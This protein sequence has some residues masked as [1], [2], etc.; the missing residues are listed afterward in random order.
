MANK[1]ICAGFCALTIS[2]LTPAVYSDSAASGR[3]DRLEWFLNDKFGMFI[4]W[5]VYSDPAGE[6][7][8]RRGGNYSEWIMNDA[9][10]PAEE[11]AREIAAKFNPVDFEA[12]EW[13]SLAKNAGMKYIVITAK[14]HDGFAMY[15]SR[16]SPYNIVDF[17]PFKRDPMKELAAAC[18]KHGIRLCF[19]YSQT[20]DW[21]HP[22][23]EGN[24]WDYPDTSSKN[25]TRYLEEKCIP[26][27]RELLA[28]YGPIGLI[29]FDTPGQISLEQS[30]YLTDLVHELQPE[31]LVNGRVGHGQG[32]YKEM[33]DNYLPKPG[34]RIDDAWET[35]ATMN[36]SYGY[37]KIDDD[38]KSTTRLIHS[39]IAVVCRG[40]NYLLNVGPTGKGVIQ[41]ESVE[42]LRGIGEWLK[43]NGEAIYDTRPW[44]IDLENENV[45]FTTSADGKYLYVIC[46]EWPGEKLRLETVRLKKGSPVTMLGYETGPL[47]WKQ[48]ANYL[49]I[50]IP[51][52]IQQEG[53]RPCRHAWVFKTQAM[54]SV[55]QPEMRPAAGV[56]NQSNIFVEIVP[57]DNAEVFYTIDGSRPT[58]ESRRYSGPLTLNRST[59][60]RAR[61]YRKDHGLSRI[62]E[63]DY[64]IGFFNALDLSDVDLKNGLHARHY[65][66]VWN[67]LPN[68]NALSPTST[69]VVQSFKV[70]NADGFGIV[71]SGY[72]LL[73]EDGRYDFALRSDDGSRLS[74][75]GFEI[76]DND[77][78]HGVGSPKTGHLYARK[79]FH[80][81]EIEYF[82]NHGGQDLDVHYKV[83][84]ASGEFLPI[85]FSNLYHRVS[86]VLP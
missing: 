14:H 13:V 32:D 22:D 31:C 4:H 19:Y 42:R 30:R 21:H 1:I 46:T 79:G 36:H 35:S 34:E 85:P 54:A 77:G 16:V 29:W 24:H 7:K 38:W 9:R 52:E 65:Q 45:A 43:V 67:W 2:L 6:W 80:A 64:R 57:P 69:S 3:P 26:Q 11:Y 27:L 62:V 50:D 68:F 10:I 48:N 81:I 84:S 49:Q 83:P 39:L 56:F 59:K 61:C 86:G 70:P 37:K 23:A 28:N 74:I 8:G 17:T 53:Q 82:E 58:S 44:K 66:G 12:E 78:C 72:I 5:G 41:K 25:F 47:N 73:P 18:R 15:H 71:Y 51:K 63:N 33:G 75:N 76:V 20:K 55:P 40:G 60:V